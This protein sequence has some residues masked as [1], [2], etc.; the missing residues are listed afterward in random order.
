MKL[1]MWGGS[2][3]DMMYLSIADLKPLGQYSHSYSTSGDLNFPVSS[4]DVSFEHW[5]ASASSI[6]SVWPSV[7]KIDPRQRL[8]KL[9]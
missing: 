3:P 8:C 6:L 4:R 5:P 9:S 1:L 2:P 7:N